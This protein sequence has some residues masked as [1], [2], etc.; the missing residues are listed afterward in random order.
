V[1]ASL[2]SE[3]ERDEGCCELGLDFGPRRRRKE[4]CCALG[5]R[6][7]WASRPDQ[8]RKDFHFFSLF[9]EFS[10]GFSKGV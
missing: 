8:R 5:Q 4:V 10:N 9:P 2:V 7:R 1:R 6:E 3:T